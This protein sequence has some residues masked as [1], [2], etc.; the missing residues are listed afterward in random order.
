LTLRA[1]LITISWSA[2]LRREKVGAPSTPPLHLAPSLVFTPRSAYTS[3]N[4][5]PFLRQGVIGDTFHYK[6]Q[7]MNAASVDANDK[8]A[9]VP[10]YSDLVYPVFPD[11]AYE[12][13]TLF[14][15]QKTSFPADFIHQVITARKAAVAKLGAAFTV[16]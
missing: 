5:Q 16:S 7:S 8:V 2:V 12:V 4:L 11:M 15:P 14:A 13:P 3:L 10:A 1:R 9:A 6:G